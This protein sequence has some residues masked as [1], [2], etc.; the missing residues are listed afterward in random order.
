MKLN[1]PN[2]L[3]SK[4]D[5]ALCRLSGTPA[6]RHNRSAQPM[7]NQTIDQQGTRGN[8]Q[9]EHLVR[10]YQTKN[11][12]VPLL[13]EVFGPLVSRYPSPIRHEHVLRAVFGLPAIFLRQIVERLTGLQYRIRKIGRAGRIHHA[14]GVRRGRGHDGDQ[15]LGLGGG[16]R[17]D[18]LRIGFAL[19]TFFPISWQYDCAYRPFVWT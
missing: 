3:S 17:T 14:I 12:H 5:A 2:M 7:N 9:T 16:T 6:L 8:T 18:R 15:R 4:W 19:R 13:R 11:G 10:S 1:M